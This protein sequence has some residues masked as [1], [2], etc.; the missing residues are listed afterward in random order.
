[1]I[2]RPIR[3]A[4]QRGFTL[5]EAMIVVVILAILASIAYPSYLEQ[6]RKA[7]RSVA[8]SALLEM[9]NRQ[10]QRFFTA[11][12]YGGLPDLGYGSVPTDSGGGRYLGFGRSGATT[13]NTADI[14]YKVI[15]ESTTPAY[16]GAPSCYKLKA[17][18]QGNQANDDCGDF[19]LFSDNRKQVVN[20]TSKP[21][22]ECW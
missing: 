5:I 16:C 21:A 4:R 6:I 7:N 14:I 8:K 19:V 13:T 11:R 10:E 20:R 15:V 17:T 22:G 2:N 1:M 9:A 18:P 3:K 12:S